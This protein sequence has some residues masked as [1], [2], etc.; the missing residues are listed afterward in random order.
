MSFNLPIFTV[1]AQKCFAVLLMLTLVAVAAKSR[2]AKHGS[3]DRSP[4]KRVLIVL[5]ACIQACTRRATSPSQ[6]SADFGNWSAVVECARNIL[7]HTLKA[8]YRLPSPGAA[9]PHF[10][11]R[12]QV[13][14]PPLRPHLA[15]HG[16][17]AHLLDHFPAGKLG[18]KRS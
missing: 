5:F 4:I 12:M 15:D 9:S 7:S 2:Q 18:T 13:I 11:Q 16:N 10:L 14:D 17:L 3:T 6:R 1:V 8:E